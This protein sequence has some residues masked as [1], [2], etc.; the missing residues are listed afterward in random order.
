M[1]EIM[2]NWDGCVRE[3]LCW[4]AFLNIICSMSRISARLLRWLYWRN[5]MIINTSLPADRIVQG[6][7]DSFLISWY[8]ELIRSFIQVRRF[9]SKELLIIHISIVHS[10]YLPICYITSWFLQ[11]KLHSISRVSQEPIYNIQ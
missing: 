7:W 5:E 1:I 3:R 10:N 8:F 9:F 6:H 2:W 4:S 11:G